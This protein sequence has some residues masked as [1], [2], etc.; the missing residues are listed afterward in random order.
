MSTAA[1]VDLADWAA[2]GATEIR[3]LVDAEK[4]TSVEYSNQC[5]R[6]IEADNKSGRQFHALISTMP[7]HLAEQDAPAC[8]G[9]LNT[10]ERKS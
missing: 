10:P 6:R 8:D 5:L 3:K 9:M 2:F 7:K 4:L 1:G